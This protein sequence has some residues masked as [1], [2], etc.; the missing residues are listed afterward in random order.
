MPKG[1]FGNLIALPLQK[2]A[3]AQNNSVFVDESL[4]PHSDQWAFLASI[5]RMS[6]GD[7]EPAII[8]AMGNRDPVG[9]AYVE[10]KEDAEPWK[11]R[12][13]R[14]QKLTCPLPASLR[15]TLANQVYFEKSGLPQPL[16]N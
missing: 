3:R 16:A 7:I 2:R 6:P 13:T 12:D 1:G 15:I 5:Q 9:V 11:G 10:D 8:R 14:S 4:E